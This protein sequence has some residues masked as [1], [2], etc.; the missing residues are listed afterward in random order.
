VNFARKTWRAP[1]A[2]YKS[3]KTMTGQQKT[4]KAKAVAGDLQGELHKQ[5]A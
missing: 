3:R 2:P 1:P 4:R 5:H